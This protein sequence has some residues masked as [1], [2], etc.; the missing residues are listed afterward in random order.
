M[1]CE[2]IIKLI[3]TLPKTVHPTTEHG[4]FC[5]DAWQPDHMIPLGSTSHTFGAYIHITVHGEFTDG[6]TSEALLI[7]SALQHPPGL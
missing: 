2:G 6:K 3:S 4:L 1:G 5:F 7:H